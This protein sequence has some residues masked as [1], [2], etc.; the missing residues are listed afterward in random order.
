MKIKKLLPIFF[1]LT[2]LLTSCQ[3]EPVIP[4][5]EDIPFPPVSA[6]STHGFYVL[7]EGIMGTNKASLDYCDYAAGNYRRNI[8]N[9]ANPNATLGLGDVGNDLQVYGSKLY[10]IL[11]NSNKIE[12]TELKTNKRVKAITLKDARFITFHNGK[13]Y[14]SAYGNIENPQDANGCVVEIDTTS[15]NITRSVSVGRQPEEL[16]VVNNRLYV[17]NS[18]GY[19]APNYEN[20]VSVI[21]ISSFNVEN[22]EVAI[23]LKRLRKDEYGDIYVSSNGNYI[24]IA[25]SLTVINTETNAIK[26]TFDIAVENLWIDGDIAY[27]IGTSYN[28]TTQQTTVSYNRINVNTETL[29][30]GN[31]ITDGTTA[32]IKLPTCVAVC[33]ET[34]NIYICDAIDYTVPGTLYCFDS[35]GRKRW[36]V[37]A[38][39]IPAHIAFVKK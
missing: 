6:T 36:S 38:G 34:K 17:A 4:Q 1:A 9:E 10:T 20:T 27:I 11:T 15:L 22:I 25:P 14:V 18:G 37:T 12:I 3:K 24:D 35:E 2:I 23:N 39:D 33:P 19:S 8:Y 32:Q 5:G 21:D 26:T 16:C 29:L 30:S 7:N 13:A 31:F 28:Q